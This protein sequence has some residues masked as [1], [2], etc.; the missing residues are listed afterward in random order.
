MSAVKGKYKKSKDTISNIISSTR[1]LLEAK[2]YSNL[3]IRDI[4]TEAGVSTGSFYTHFTSKEQLL[5]T[6]FT[7]TRI[8]RKSLDPSTFSNGNCKTRLENFVKQ[9]AWMNMSNEPEE[10]KKILSFEN[11]IY[12]KNRHFG[13]YVIEILTYGLENGEVKNEFSAERLTDILMVCLRGC[14]HEWCRS[15]GSYDLADQMVQ[16][17]WLLFASVWTEPNPSIPIYSNDPQV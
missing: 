7:D 1:K 11:P 10:L 12:T 16:C 8:G 13:D 5:A 17:T 14:S 9:Y 3:T 15:N 6:V 2:G 4:C